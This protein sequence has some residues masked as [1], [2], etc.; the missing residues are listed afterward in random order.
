MSAA[1]HGC[2]PAAVVILLAWDGKADTWV[3]TPRSLRLLLHKS[4]WSG[5]SDPG[6]ASHTWQPYSN[7]IFW[8][9]KIYESPLRLPSNGVCV[10]ASRS[11][12][13]DVCVK[14]SAPVSEGQSTG[15]TRRWRG[16]AGSIWR[17]SE[18]AGPCGGRHFHFMTMHWINKARCLP[19]FLLN[20]C[21]KCP[22]MG[23]AALRVYGYRGGRR[24]GDKAHFQLSQFPTHR[25]LLRFTESAR[26][27]LSS[28]RATTQQIFYEQSNHLRPIVLHFSSHPP[29]GTACLAA[30]PPFH[31]YSVNLWVMY[32]KWVTGNTPLSARTIGREVPREPVP[33]RNETRRKTQQDPK[34]FIIA[35]QSYKPVFCGERGVEMLPTMAWKPW[36]PIDFFPPGFQTRRV[37]VFV[38]GKSKRVITFYATEKYAV[39][40]QRKRCNLSSHQQLVFSCACGSTDFLNWFSLIMIRDVSGTKRFALN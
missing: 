23:S 32:S 11:D 14:V 13:E 28:A 37:S 21:E 25:R 31:V 39:K 2:F 40:S 20:M 5:Q 18:Q 7:L 9:G 38:R 27:G 34:R 15:R 26:I 22:P 8:H 16:R 17:R 3:Q 1:P 4:S 6:N 35:P 19:P 29:E 30:L 24:K 33:F 36:F 12:R 10:C